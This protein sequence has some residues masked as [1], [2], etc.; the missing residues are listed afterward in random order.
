MINQ[1]GGIKKMKSLKFFLVFLL[2]IS[3]LAS[4][5]ITAKDRPVS[6][7]IFHLSEKPAD[8]PYSPAILVKD[9]LYISGQLATDPETGK[10]EGGTMTQQSERVIKNIEILLKKAGLDFSHIVS[11][12]AFITDFKEFG[13]FNAVFRKYFPVHPP[14]RATV[15]VAG[16]ALNAKIE[17]S[18][19][20]VK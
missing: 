5:N 11:V 12:S 9:T 14:T 10:F 13:E 3:T 16:L 1:S 7:K 8:L 4:F 17:I 6:K 20:A 18:A 19:V 15:Q 2:G